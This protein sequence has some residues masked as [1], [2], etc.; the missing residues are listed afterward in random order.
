MFN[1][2]GNIRIFI[3]L[4]VRKE[5]NASSGK[6]KKRNARCGRWGSDTDTMNVEGDEPRLQASTERNYPVTGIDCAG[7]GGRD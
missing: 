6:K 7:P 1:S 2:R 5:L 3:V 4:P